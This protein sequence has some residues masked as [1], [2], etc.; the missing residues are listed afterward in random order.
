MIDFDT[1][2]GKDIALVVWNTEKEDDARVFIGEIIQ[3]DNKFYFINE[4][5]K[6]NLTLS[7]E[8]FNRLKKVPDEL[9]ETLLYADFSFSVSLGNLL[10][11]S[12][13]GYQPTDIKWD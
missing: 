1:V 2:K 5:Q 3:K 7:R 11:S 12:T 10:D 4:S 8:L 6:W 13:E 9:K